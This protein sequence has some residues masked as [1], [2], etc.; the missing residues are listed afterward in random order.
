MGQRAILFHY[1]KLEEVEKLTYLVFVGT[2]QNSIIRQALASSELL[3]ALGGV[4][5]IKGEKQN[6]VGNTQL[7]P[8]Q[9]R[10]K[11]LR[12]HRTA[13]HA[14]GIHRKRIMGPGSRRSG[15]SR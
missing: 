6:A 3:K 2:D 14:A 10:A 7:H 5:R 15:G 9:L 4:S 8:C 13:T 11:F 1:G 12:Q